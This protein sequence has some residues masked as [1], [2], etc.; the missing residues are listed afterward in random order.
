MNTEIEGCVNRATVVADDTANPI[1][2]GGVVGALL[3]G[4]TVRNCKHYGTLYFQLY[5]DPKK[6][7][8]GGGVA[9][10]SVDG[11][12]ID[13]CRFGGQF[14]GKSGDPVALT[15]DDVCSDSNFTGSGNTL[16]DGK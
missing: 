14:Q 10:T 16:W 9:G 5:G 4:S 13:D 12:T 3:E 1:T 8:A 11:T 6:T 7:F 15:A 2:A